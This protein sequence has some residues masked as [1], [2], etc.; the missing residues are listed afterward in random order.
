MKKE[1]AGI[2]ELYEDMSSNNQS[3]IKGNSERSS[4]T[5][6][7]I[8]EE[9]MVYRVV[10]LK[11]NKLE[12]HASKFGGTNLYISGDILSSE[13]V[14][15]KDSFLCQYRLNIAGRKEPLVFLGYG[16][17]VLKKC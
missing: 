10:R 11:Y 16:K 8:I 17:Q 5:G 9:T 4:I 15:S 13:K 7:F 12:F 2:K 3:F 6:K 14:D 1:F